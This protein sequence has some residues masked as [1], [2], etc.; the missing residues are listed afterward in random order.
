MNRCPCCGAEITTLDIDIPDDLLLKFALIAHERDIAL[1]Q[2]IITAL[3][4]AS[5]NVIKNSE[6]YKAIEEIGGSNEKGK[7]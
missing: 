3:I 7:E 5:E 6:L 2:L 4:T 1:N